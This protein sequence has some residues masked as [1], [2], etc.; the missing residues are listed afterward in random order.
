MKMLQKDYLLIK[1]LII[2]KKGEKVISIE[3]KSKQ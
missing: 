3:M 2:E 1:Q